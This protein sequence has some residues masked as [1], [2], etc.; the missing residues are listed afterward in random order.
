M[1]ARDS[2]FT[3]ARGP[4]TS[5]IR[6]I[7]RMAPLLPTYQ[8]EGSV[9]EENALYTSFA[10]VKENPKK[11][12]EIVSKQFPRRVILEDS[13]RTIDLGGVTKEFISILMQ[14][15]LEKSAFPTTET[16]F[17]K[18]IAQIDP[19]NGQPQLNQESRAIYQ[20]LGKFYSLLDEKNK[21]RTDKFVTGT[22]FHQGFFQ[23][24]RKVGAGAAPED[25]R[26]E[27]A[28]QIIDAESEEPSWAAVILDPKDPEKL[29]AYAVALGCNPQEAKEYLASTEELID[30][31]VAAARAFYE[32]ARPQFQAKIK[33]T[34]PLVLAH[35]VQGKPI[36]KES[37]LGALSRKPELSEE[38]YQWVL[39]KI[40]TSDEAWRK[41]F[42]KAITGNEVLSPGMKI[43][44][45]ACWRGEGKFEIHTCF[46]SLDIPTN[47]KKTDLL[48]ALDNVLDEGYNTA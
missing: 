22:V 24:V 5:E 30:Q 4:F 41:K 36:S 37:V 21:D 40:E 9:K 14:S 44:I 32:G 1:E 15:L 7:L 35:T 18:L 20:R 29:E 23:I 47:V 43:Q 17:P 26:K 48:A 3:N 42:V 6:D 28:K 16:G 12:L 11:Y 46:N 19:K 13:P 31:V 39:D 25:L 10:D 27:A 8:R 45:G 33:D 2:A 34:D 38:R